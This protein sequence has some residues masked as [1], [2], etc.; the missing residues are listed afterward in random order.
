MEVE[1]KRSRSLE[2]SW[3]AQSTST[4]MPPVR[5]KATCNL[6]FR[7]SLGFK[8]IARK[9]KDSKDLIMHVGSSNNAERD[10]EFKTLS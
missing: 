7:A 4:K 8:L 9:V 1:N 2:V 3:Q 5:G 10:R 6:E